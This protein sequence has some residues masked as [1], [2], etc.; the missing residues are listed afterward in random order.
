V[1][2]LTRFDPAFD[3]PH[4]VSAAGLVPAL[5]LV[6]SAG[7]YDVLE[8]LAVGSPNA[9]AKASRLVGG[10]LAVAASIDDLDLLRHDGM[11]RLFGRVRGGEPSQEVGV[12]LVELLASA[13]TTPSA[14]STATPST[15]KGP[16]PGAG[17]L[18]PLWVGV[19]RHRDPIPVPVLGDHADESLRVVGDHHHR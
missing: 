5:R 10:I 15:A 16:D 9:A 13:S 2:L 6:E 11:P 8:G 19:R 18:G 3:D 4:L 1:K 12:D 14:G 17:R 7:F